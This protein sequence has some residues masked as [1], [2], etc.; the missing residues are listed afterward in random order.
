[1]RR[2]SRRPRLFRIAAAVLLGAAVVG[3]GGARLPLIVSSPPDPPAEID[4]RAITEAGCCSGFSW[5]DDGDDVTFF[6]RDLDGRQGLWA[7]DTTTLEKTFESPAPR[8]T[9]PSGRYQIE[10][11]G[12]PNSA[13]L[14]D[15]LLDETWE[16]SLAGPYLLF[17]PL[18]D[19][20]L[21]SVRQPGILPNYARLASIYTAS[22]DGSDVRLLTRMFGGPIGWFP[23]GER[24]LL[25][26]RQTLDEP[27]GIWIYNLSS[28][29][30]KQ[31]VTGDFIRRTSISPGGRFV[32][33]VRSLT[34]DP[35]DSGLWLHE[36][37]SET[38]HRIA[39]V[40]SYR[41]HPNGRG[42][43]VIPP[44]PGGEGDHSIWWT[45]IASRETVELTE[46]GPEDLRIS[47]FEWQLSPDGRRAVYRHTD[48]L[49]LWI[50]DFG[51][52][53]DRVLDEPPDASAPNRDYQE[54]SANRGAGRL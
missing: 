5:S 27:S 51:K 9:S 25:S 29:E 48:D 11:T 31:I 45:D 37:A 50:V 34:E 36:T 18:E 33:F 53:L 4:N 12:T 13:I 10:Q 3:A 43:L 54:S 16:F 46:N 2:K 49:S 40:G 32:A 42:L 28:S 8:L 15:T 47:N 6:D 24:V 22:V 17:S 1:M 20:V 44:R 23:D 26:G 39:V 41:W 52:V 14:T 7:L 38:N 30:L 21:F 19:R 35:S